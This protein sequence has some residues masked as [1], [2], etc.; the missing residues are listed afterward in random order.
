MDIKNNAIRIIDN[1]AENDDDNGPY[2][3]QSG[4]LEILVRKTVVF[5]EVR[6]YADSLMSGAAIMVSFAHVDSDTRNRIFDYLNGV[7]YIINATVSKVSDSILLYAPEQ[8]D[9]D[10]QTVRKTSWLSR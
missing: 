2:L 3:V 8:V 9:V 10:K 7:S 4:K 5:D 6:D 1:D